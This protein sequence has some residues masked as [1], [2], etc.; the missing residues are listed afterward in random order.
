[1]LGRDE[2][3]GFPGAHDGHRIGAAQLRQGRPCRLDESGAGLQLPLDEMRDDLGVRLGAEVVAFGQQALLEPQVILDDA[4]VD[5]D[6]AAGAVGVGMGVRFR[7]SAVR[8]PP[9]VPHADRSGHGLLTDELGQARDLAGMAPD[10]EGP[11][12]EGGQPGGVIPPV[13]ETP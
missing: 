11:A 6:Q 10:L 8:G 4:V 7:G 5:D 3:V 1:M 12:I 9:C 2:A 13:L